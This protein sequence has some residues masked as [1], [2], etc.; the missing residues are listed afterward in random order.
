MYVWWEISHTLG[1]LIIPPGFI[2]D[3]FTRGCMIYPLKS[4]VLQKINHFFIFWKPKPKKKTQKIQ[5]TS[6]KM[7]STRSPLY[8]IKRSKVPI[9]LVQF[10]DYLNDPGFGLFQNFDG[11]KKIK[12]LCPK[13]SIT[14]I[15]CESHKFTTGDQQ[16][17]Y[18]IDSAIEDCVIIVPTQKSI[19]DRTIAFPFRVQHKEDDPSHKLMWVSD[20]RGRDYPHSYPQLIPLRPLR[21]GDEVTFDYNLH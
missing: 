21:K 18:G 13:G 3:L 19:D 15:P 16:H 17:K 9:D 8:I 2:F 20:E 10:P 5:K 6:V 1:L 14:T 11:E 4:I 12:F 7:N